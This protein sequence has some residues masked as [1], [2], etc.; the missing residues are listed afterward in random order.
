[1][2]TILIAL[3]L[4]ASLSSQASADEPLDSMLDNLEQ[5]AEQVDALDRGEVTVYELAD[6]RSEKAGS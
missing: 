5:F 1:M 2:K 3:A 6:S 4:I